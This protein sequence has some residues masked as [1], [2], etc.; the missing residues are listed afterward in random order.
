MWYDSAR[1]RR[2]SGITERVD[3]R[4][5]LRVRP[6]LALDPFRNPVGSLVVVESEL[7]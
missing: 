2:H 6:N 7:V 3:L 5:D 4:V 1:R